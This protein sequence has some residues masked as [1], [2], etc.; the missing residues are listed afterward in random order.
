MRFPSRFSATW[1]GGGLPWS[2]RA[3]QRG[4]P[5]AHDPLVQCHECGLLQRNPPLPAGDAVRCARCN[6]TLHRNL[7]NSLDRTLALTSAGVIFFVIANS[8]P[9]LSIQLQGRTTETTLFT[10][11]EV[12]YR[13]G[14]WSLSLVVFFT[15]IL[16]PGIR[17]ALLLSVLV[18]LRMNHVGR[19]F[20]T[21]FRYGLAV[22]SRMIT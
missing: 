9:L 16:A 15:A 19:G 3:S 2:P 6:A 20:P 18:P 8:F 10:G 21:L 22:G 13:Q 14:F 17:L 1:G 12:L 7:P 11:I 5:M 4:R